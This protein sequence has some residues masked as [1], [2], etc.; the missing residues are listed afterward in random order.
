MLEEEEGARVVVTLRLCL[1]KD[2]HF[3]PP[4]CF[5]IDAHDQDTDE[6][7]E[8]GAMPNAMIRMLKTTTSRATKYGPR[9]RCASWSSLAVAAEGAAAAPPPPP[10]AAA[11]VVGVVGA[12]AAL[13]PLL[14]PPRFV[15][16]PGVLRLDRVGEG[17]L[18][19]APASS[20]SWAA[21]CFRGER[22]RGG[23]SVGAFPS[24]VPPRTLAMMSPSTA[25][26]LL[27]VVVSQEG[28]AGIACVGWER[29]TWEEENTRQEFRFGA[30]PIKP[31]PASQ[32]RV[33]LPSDAVLV[34]VCCLVVVVLGR[35]SAMHHASPCG[36]AFFGEAARGGLASPPLMPFCL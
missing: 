24:A 33:N 14:P 4:M 23:D 25:G 29:G 30:L 11:L 36:V 13:Y 31:R 10:A 32:A 3:D 2:A 35:W 7:E 5:R 26:S 21:D 15:A 22:R 19:A 18:A 34:I 20:S 6:D 27:V 28:V 1:D 12:E 16:L 9:M 8:E 17:V